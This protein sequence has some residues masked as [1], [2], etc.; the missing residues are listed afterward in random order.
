ME[1]ANAQTACR[2]CQLVKEFVG[3]APQLV[4]ILG[5]LKFDGG[6]VIPN[7][8]CISEIA[9]IC[10]FFLQIAALALKVDKKFLFYESISDTLQPRYNL[11]DAMLR[12]CD[13]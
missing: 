3:I 10:L 5:L 11:K 12:E 2:A 1:G 4:Q 7:V 9:W 13:S 8:F 6:A